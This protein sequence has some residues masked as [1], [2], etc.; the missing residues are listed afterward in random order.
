MTP[1][2][3]CAS[4]VVNVTVTPRGPTAR[5]A[6]ATVGYRGTVEID[7]LAN[8]TLGA[9][10]FSSLT[11]TAP[12]QGGTATVTANNRV[13]FTAAVNF[14][15]VAS[16][17]HTICDRSIPVQLCSTAVVL[18]AVS[19]QVVSCEFWAPVFVCV[20]LCSQPPTAAPDA[21]T[22]NQDGASVCINVTANDQA[23]SGSSINVT[24]VSIVTP[25]GQSGSYSSSSSC[26]KAE[27]NRR[28]QNDESTKMAKKV[29]TIKRTERKH[30]LKPRRSTK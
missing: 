15:G 27:L 10:G 17:N 16:F 1:K 13:L 5:P 20:H 9:A 30:N 18:V 22:L 25:A 3:N 24:S 23:A 26:G 2:P 7:V 21:A 12:G 14:N 28:E 4:A 29:K 8:A 6:Y 19:G 11:I